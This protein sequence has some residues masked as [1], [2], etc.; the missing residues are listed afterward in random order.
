MA[1]SDDET[2][3]TAAIKKTKSRASGARKKTA[4]AR[5]SSA[6]RRRAVI[7]DGVRTPFVK[8]FSEMLKM[9]TIAL[10]VAA[11]KALIDKSELPLKEIDA[12]VWGGVILPSTAP[13]VAREIALD[14]RL[15]P[16][17]HGMTV[18]RACISG[19]QAILNAVAEIE[20]G[21]A[22]VIIAG[23]SDSTSNG[24]LQF[25]QKVVHALGPLNFGRPTP[26]DYLNALGKLMPIHEC[27]PRPPKVAERTTKKTMGQSCEEMAK[28][29]QISR[30][31][32]DELA[33]R[34]HHRAAEAIRSGRYDREVAPVQNPAGQW[35]HS[36]RLVRADTNLE[37]LGKLRPAFSRKGGTLTAG[38]SSPLTDGAAATLIMSE[39]KARALGYQPLATFR[40]W[41]FAAVDPAD[42]LLM[43][44][45]FA[46]PKALERA[47]MN[48]A[49]VD[50]VD[51][52]EA[53]A[54]QVL[55]ITKMLGSKAFAQT[56]FGRNRA[57]GEVDPDRLNVH[58]GS[59]AIGHPFG[60]T[61]A[62]M[63]NTMANEL[64]LTGKET[65]LLGLC[66]A[67][68]MGCGAVLERVD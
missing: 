50:L 3:T 14:L 8:A 40:S 49:D 28:R 34:S 6:G 59:V 29:N 15:P 23:G 45:A 33:M 21:N 13:N 30:E 37:K 41:A 22:D 17:V 4:K 64:H 66:A 11:T 48:L 65:A 60:A 1:T 39:E 19:L 2:A 42:Q 27:L 63:A 31:A 51:M 67:G 5:A 24:A 9:D 32:Q 68:A 55:C 16:S 56:H 10:G 47:G 38:N 7:V 20:R 58:G 61:G 54:A 35:V 52:H 46:M 36:D 57:F 12:M 53:F 62:R 43:G 25:P 18:T 26:A 44:P